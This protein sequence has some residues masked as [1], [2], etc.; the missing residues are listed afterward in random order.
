MNSQ[1]YGLDLPVPQM[2]P[3]KKW[4][5]WI[6]RI[7]GYLIFMPLRWLVKYLAGCNNKGEWRFR[8]SE[9]FH[10]FCWSW[11][12][13]EWI[14]RVL[15]KLEVEDP[16]YSHCSCCGSEEYNT[17]IEESDDVYYKQFYEPISDGSSS[18][19]DGTLYYWS[20]YV[21]CPKCGYRGHYSDSN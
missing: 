6:L 19:M 2:R 10:D 4:Y 13:I 21:N 15:W 20:A 8:F 7:Y 3:P 11:R 12:K 16:G 1:Y 14:H 18:T 9:K 17:V 5:W